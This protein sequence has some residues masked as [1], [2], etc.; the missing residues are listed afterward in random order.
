[1]SDTLEDKEKDIYISDN[2]V[3]TNSPN[4]ESLC[5]ESTGLLPPPVWD[6]DSY[7]TRS[8]S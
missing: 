5:R 7:D 8:R 2:P 6:G 4:S 3:K 1:M